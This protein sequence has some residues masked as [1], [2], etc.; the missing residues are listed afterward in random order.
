MPSAATSITMSWGF[1]PEQTEPT[2]TRSS[3]LIGG[4]HQLTVQVDALFDVVLGRTGELALAH[5][6]QTSLKSGKN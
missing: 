6:E 2:T 1:W 4:W 5:I 3:V